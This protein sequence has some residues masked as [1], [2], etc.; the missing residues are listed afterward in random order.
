MQLKPLSLTVRLSF[1]L[2][3]LFS[4]LPLS[5]AQDTRPIVRLIYFRPFN[6]APQPGIEARM[7]ELIKDVQRFFANQMQAHGFGRK[8]FQIE[9][10]T[11]G[12]AVVYH[13]VGRFTDRYYSNLSHTWDVWEEIDEQFDTS[14]NIYFTAIDISSERLNDGGTCGIAGPRGSVGGKGLI[15][16]SG[17]CFNVELA[18][19]E[20]GHIFGLQHDFRG[21]PYIM[22]YESDRNQLSKCAA[23]WLDVHNA[24]NRGPLELNA[25]YS[26]QIR[27]FPPSLASQPNA[28][29]LRFAVPDT[30]GLHQA[31]LLT[32]TLTGS[33]QGSDE[34]FSCQ[35]LNGSTN[36][37]VEFVTTAL[38]SKNK[39]VS[40]QV[41]DVNGNFAW[42]GRYPIY[43]DALPL[44]ET[45]EVV[46]IPDPH[47]ARA[48]QEVI[49]DSITTYTMLYLRK[50]H[51]P[52]YKITDLTGLEYAH[53]LTVLNL[54]NVP[55]II[56]VRVEG[57]E[58]FSRIEYY[59]NRNAVSDVSPLTE[60]TQLTELDIS[61]NPL[62]FAAI[63]RHI[64][65]MQ[66]K[67]VKV[68]F[69]N[70]AHIALL[71]VSGN[72]QEGL[73]G[74]T[75]GLPLVLRVQDERGQPMP[76]VPVTFAIDTGE[77][78]LAPTNTVSDPDGKARTN[79]TLGWAPGMTTI[80]AT[81]TDTP[82]YVRFTAT[83][84]V[85]PSQIA[86]DVNSDGSVDVEDLVLVAASFGVVP[87]PDVLPDTDVNND[88]EVNDEDIA[89]VLAA[90]ETEP[91][92]PTAVRTAERLQWWIAEAK[93]RSNGDGTFQRGIAVLE[94]L[95]ARLLPTETAL[96]PNYPNPFNPETWIPYQL[97]ASADVSISIY[98]ADGK[99]VRKLDLGQQAVGIYQDKSRAA[100]WDG[101]N[102]VGE[103]VASGV[104]FYTLT[105]GEYT[106]TRKMLIRK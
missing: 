6:R 100:Y 59:F 20:L 54:R 1:Y 55:I 50:L 22:S 37:T 36:T 88:G 97:A 96:L 101:R 45:A 15:P 78:V 72:S 68:S 75:L 26:S 82:S 86:A 104:Y 66:A 12:N 103:P 52:N 42:S 18:A 105:A 24:F 28:I 30:E 61:K 56:R 38:T 98:T 73:A 51:V 23:E 10:D 49:G 80:R 63:N 16:A 91:A 77:G 34:L 29:H 102:D 32:P 99:L 67:G 2:M 74:K 4:F 14:K 69:D 39:Q 33:A 62:N 90:L 27:L 9:T 7:D 87:I 17:P 70:V 84:V 76:D 83:T 71:K 93:R 5:F 92:A 40:L 47:L 13:I 19:H 94:Q 58:D 106:A 85:L 53:N 57:D 89:L 3:I 60:L 8:T 48:V 21:G 41:I 46:S 95:L 11:T 44:S 43:V 64:P 65:A 35:T 25:I 81:T 79:L 31:Q